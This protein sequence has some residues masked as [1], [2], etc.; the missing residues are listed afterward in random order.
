MESFLRRIL[1]NTGEKSRPRWKGNCKLSNVREPWVKS[2][3]K[4]TRIFN[5]F[6]FLSHCN[7][8]LWVKQDLEKLRQT[9]TPTALSATE[10]SSSLERI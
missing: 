8:S 4:I 6:I 3:T 10:R 9:L 7:V 1:E 5:A 2:W